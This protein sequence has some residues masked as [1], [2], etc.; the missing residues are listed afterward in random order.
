MTDNV[1]ELQVVGKL[2]IP[3]TKILARAA[4]AKLRNVIVVGVDSDG[5]FY[6]ASSK[7]DG[8]DVIWWL[9]MAKK[10]LLEIADA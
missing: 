5:E 1:I 3:P 9:E 7:A 6:F 10:K 2:D 4:A 8:G